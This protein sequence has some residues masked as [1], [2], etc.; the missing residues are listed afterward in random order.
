MEEGNWFAM[1]GVPLIAAEGTRAEGRTTA[2]EE[3]GGAETQHNN[4][5]EAESLARQDVEVTQ[6]DGAERTV[7]TAEIPTD[8]VEHAVVAVDTALAARAS[9]KVVAALVGDAVRAPA[10]EVPATTSTGGSTGGDTDERAHAA[11]LEVALL[12][13]RSPMREAPP[14]SAGAGQTD[15]SPAAAEAEV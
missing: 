8:G 4:A 5:R 12:A 13:I 15:S 14:E 2:E 9:P 6:D 7:P 10:E 1:T 3:G 11:D